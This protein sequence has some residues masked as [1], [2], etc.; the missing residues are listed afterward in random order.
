[1]KADHKKRGAPVATSDVKRGAPV[2]TSDVRRGAT[3]AR[4]DVRRGTAI[5]FTY[6]TAHNEA[7]TLV[8]RF[9]HCA[10]KLLAKPVDAN[11]QHQKI[12]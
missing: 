9:S 3:L 7:V 5:I 4:C 8:G 10:S 11:S 6:P 2:D 1:M 12:R